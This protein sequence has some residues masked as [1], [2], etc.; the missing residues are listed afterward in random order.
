MM[1]ENLL[2]WV[3]GKAALAP[4]ILPLLGR[5]S[6]GGEPLHVPFCGGLGDVFHWLDNTDSERRG[7]VWLS[8]ACSPLVDFWWYALSPALSPLLTSAVQAAWKNYPPYEG[9]SFYR[10]RENLNAWIQQEATEMEGLVAFLTVNRFGHNGLW[11]VNK[12]GL[13]NVPAGTPAKDPVVGKR[14][15]EMV[16]G[17]LN[18]FSER[19]FDG[20]LISHLTWQEKLDKLLHRPTGGVVYL[21]PPYFGTFGGYNAINMTGEVAQRQLFLQCQTL[22]KAG[23]DVVMCNSLESRVCLDVLECQPELLETSRRGTMNRDGAKRQAVGEVIYNWR[24][25]AD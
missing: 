9:D 18:D 2:K 15:A 13:C 16:L 14:V 11:R 8:D 12:Q 24:H 23:Y 17:R 1:T 6:E 20:V 4:T 19:R 25:H 10:Y 7:P 22:Y 21:D 3:G 5:W